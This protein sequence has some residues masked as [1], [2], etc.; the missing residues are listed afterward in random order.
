[1]RTPGIDYRKTNTNHIMETAQVLGIEAARSCIISQ[2]NF[3]VGQYGIKID[4]R[5]IQL[6]ADEMTYKG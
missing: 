4:N 3:T 5:H 6:L 2:I 1:M